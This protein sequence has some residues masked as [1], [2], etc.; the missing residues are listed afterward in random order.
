MGPKGYWDV[1]G[2][3][4]GVLPYMG[5]VAILLLGRVWFLSSLLWDRV[6]K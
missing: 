3:G 6:Y 1:C 4:V 2:V 5:Y